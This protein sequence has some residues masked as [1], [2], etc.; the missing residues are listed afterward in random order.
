MTHSNVHVLGD[1]GGTHVRFA[2]VEDGKPQAIQ[3]YKGLDH[4]SLIHALQHYCADTG[5][6]SVSALSIATAAREEIPGQ[7]WQFINSHLGR[8]QWII[9]TK[10][11]AD[12]GYPV[13]RVLNDFEA[14]T[15]GVS[16]LDVEHQEILRPAGPGVPDYTRCVTGPGTGLGLA[17]LEKLINGKF[18]VHGTFGVHAPAAARTRE[19]FEILEMIEKTKSKA[20]AVV[21]EDVISG[22]GIYNIYDAVC[23]KSGEPKVA[24][25]IREVFNNFADPDVAQAMRLF[26]EFFGTYAGTALIYG[27]AL[28]GI[29]LTGGIMDRLIEKKAFDLASF[30]K[31]FEYDAVDPVKRA[32]ETAKITH[33]KDEYIPLRGLIAAEENG[34]PA[35]SL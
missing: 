17:Y 22:S 16:A 4:K 26:H 19:Q 28:G 25:D 20:T 10:E 21:F 14:A 2:I 13:R 23:Q 6:E 8:H 3:K 9:D 24:A 32:L 5:I 29:Y 30:L 11:L 33:I 1:F 34:V 15:W 18:H 31:Y 7:R 27:H 35:L 12:T